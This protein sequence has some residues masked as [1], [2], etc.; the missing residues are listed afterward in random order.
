MNKYKI[1]NNKMNISLTNKKLIL[2][3]NN[4]NKYLNKKNKIILKIKKI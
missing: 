1:F 2:N 4:N 3:N